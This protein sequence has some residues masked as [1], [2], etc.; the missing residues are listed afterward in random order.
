M[1]AAELARELGVDV[2]QVKAM[3][4]N[5]ITDIWVKAKRGLTPSG[6][7]VEMLLVWLD[8]LTCA[9]C[10]GPRCKIWQL[11]RERN[12]RVKIQW[13]AFQW[14]Q[15]WR[16]SPESRKELRVAYYKSRGQIYKE[17]HKG[18]IWQEGLDFLKYEDD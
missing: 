8:G 13:A 15:Q 6:P 9:R 12:R 1:N 2:E 16:R 18:M 3:P 4:A 5:A 14:L 10:D 7:L 11:K 17:K